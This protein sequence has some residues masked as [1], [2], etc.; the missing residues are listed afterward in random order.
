MPNT[1]FTNPESFVQGDIIRPTDVDAE[2]N[3]L[4]TAFDSV[5]SDVKRAITVPA[6]ETIEITQNAAARANTIMSFDGAGAPT[7]SITLAAFNA[8]IAAVAA[9]LVLTNADV[10][11]ADAAVVSAQGQVTLATNQVSLAVAAKDAAEAALDAFD[12]T[13][14]GAKAS[15]PTLDND[16]NALIVGAQYFNTTINKLKVY[17]GSVWSPIQDGI[18]AVVADTSPALGGNLNLNNQLI[19]GG[20]NLARVTV[21]SHATTADI[22]A[23]TGNQIDWTG[24]ET[25]SAFPNAPQGGSERTLICAGASSFTA[26]ANLLIDG[27]NSGV[28]ITCA[29][30]DQM[31]VKAISTTQ[32]KLSRVR[33]DGRA[34]VSSGGLTQAQIQAYI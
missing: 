20:L 22:W 16:G 4:E 6:G 1:Y 19:S 29:A 26:G 34:Q 33:Y 17:S 3:A 2:L 25:T 14:L 30:N 13:Y 31:I 7:V 8:D 27:V 18:A 5:Q 12:D 21:A 15:D 9:D 11:L 10:V 28:T 24:V 32:F 23:A